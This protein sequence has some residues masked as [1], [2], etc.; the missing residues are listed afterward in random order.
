MIFHENRLLADDSH[1]ISYLIFLKIRKDVTKFVV[2]C[3]K[4]YRLFFEELC[5]NNSLQAGKF[6]MILSSADFYK[7]IFLKIHQS[8]KQFGFRLL[9]TQH[10]VGPDLGTKSLQ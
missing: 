8:V 2:C 4:G 5:S 3:F 10:F 1:E 7:Q 6:F 9:E